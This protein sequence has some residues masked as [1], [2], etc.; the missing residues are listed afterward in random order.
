MLPLAG[1]GLPHPDGSVE[2][3]RVLPPVAALGARYRD[4][5]L[6]EAERVARKVTAPAGA[7]RG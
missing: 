2:E 6:R 4:A 5:I 7:A 1:F 3:C